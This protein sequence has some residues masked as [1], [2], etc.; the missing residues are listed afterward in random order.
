MGYTIRLPSVPNRGVSYA[1]GHRRSGRARRILGS[2]PRVGIPLSG[3]NPRLREGSEGAGCR[4][5][6]LGNEP[7]PEANGYGVGSAT[8]LELREQMADV[9][10]DRLLRQEEPLADLTIDESVRDELKDLDL[11]GCRILADLSGRRRRERDDRAAPARAA[12]SGGRLE[13]AAVV[14]IS[15][16]DL[17]TLGRV[18]ESGIGRSRRRRFRSRVGVSLERGSRTHD[19]PLGT[20]T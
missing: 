4:R 9:G 1:R 16:E 3:G 17:P 18:H 10:L 19:S 14:S 12:P 11:A 5:E 6:V 20:R 8:R 13:A 7:T 15:V 2:P